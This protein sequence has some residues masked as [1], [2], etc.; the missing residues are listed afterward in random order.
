MCVFFLK[1]T[2]I[3]LRN[4]GKKLGEVGGEELC[5]VVVDFKGWSGGLSDE[6]EK[7]LLHPGVPALP[8]VPAPW[9]QVLVPHVAARSMYLHQSLQT[10]QMSFQ[11]CPSGETQSHCRVHPSQAG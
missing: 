6:P 1:V 2:R 11:W 10:L 8:W 5:V 4:K 3:F 7:G 9:K